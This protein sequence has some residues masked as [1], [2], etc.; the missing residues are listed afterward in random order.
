M[1]VNLFYHP[2]AFASVDEA[3]DPVSNADYAA[4]FLMQLCT[5]SGSW[6]QATG[7]YHS[8]TTDLALGYRRQVAA[9]FT[10]AVVAVRESLLPR[11]RLAWGATLQAASRSSTA[12]QSSMASRLQGPGLPNRN[13]LN[14]SVP[15]HNVQARVWGAIGGAATVNHHDAS[16][17]TPNDLSLDTGS[18]WKTRAE[19]TQVQEVAGG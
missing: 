3:F 9:I 2:Q 19:L 14:Q 12:S 8:R 10:R 16:A 13:L 7:F 5:E 1:Q 15:Q 11:L 6:E 4:R 18:C 17:A